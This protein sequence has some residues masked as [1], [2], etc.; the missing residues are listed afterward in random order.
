MTEKEIIQGCRKKNRKAQ[1]FLYEKYAPKM[2]GVC[3]RYVKNYEDAEDVLVEAFFKV[4]TKIEMFSGKGSF[5]GWIR[6]I[7]VNESLMH[8]RKNHNFRLTVEISNI[9]IK[10]T[11][12]I[13]DDLAAQDILNLLDKLPTGYRTVF[14]LYVVEG[15]K[16]REI[17]EELGISI[18]TSK[19]Q[20]I[21]AKKRLQ[22]LV[23]ANQIPGVG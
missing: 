12:T 17:A 20:L 6:R 4:M 8:L 16:H 15:Y 23:K 3:R 18:N 10:S 22:T 1:Q 13:E 2:F 21:L 11:V 7:I 19:S 5:E 9:D 14:N